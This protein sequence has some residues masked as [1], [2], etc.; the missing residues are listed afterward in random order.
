[1]PAADQFS[2]AN[3]SHSPIPT[4]SVDETSGNAEIHKAGGWQSL[5]EFQRFLDSERKTHR[6][7]L[8]VDS[9]TSSNAVVHEAADQHLAD[10]P[11]LLDN[12]RQS[13]GEYSNT[14]REDADQSEK[15]QYSQPA[16][17][18]SYSEVM[19]NDM[20]SHR[21]K[22]CDFDQQALG[23]S[24]RDKP[25]D[26]QCSRPAEQYPS[27]SEQVKKELLYTFYRQSRK[28]QLDVRCEHRDEQDE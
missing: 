24:A 4:L 1:M 10:H 2:S 23:E 20:L 21:Q 15:A 22:L 25:E 7:T 14:S 18:P 28:E 6:N 5:A 12:D 27:Q 26:G 8:G 16:E 9:S 13:S 11:Q 3:G 19:L 17:P